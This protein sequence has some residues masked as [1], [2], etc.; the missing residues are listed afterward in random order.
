[1]TAFIL[2][3]RGIWIILE[4]IGIVYKGYKLHL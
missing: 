2:L 3:I 4:I 1:M